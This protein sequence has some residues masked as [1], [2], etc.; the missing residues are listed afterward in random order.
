MTPVRFAH[1]AL[2]ALLIAVPACAAQNPASSPDPQAIKQS[3]QS[4][5]AGANLTVREA[6]GSQI[7][8]ILADTRDIDF[9][10]IVKGAPHPIVVRYTDVNSVKFE[11][12]HYVRKALFITGVVFGAL[13]LIS[14]IAWT[15]GGGI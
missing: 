14:V 13:V 8:G 4:H 11:G 1:R 5:G 10:V 7:R 12:K 2:L 3:I 6:D 9:D 15:A